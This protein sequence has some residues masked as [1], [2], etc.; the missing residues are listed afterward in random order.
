ML[1]WVHKMNC[2]LKMRDLKMPLRQCVLEEGKTC[3][4]CGECN[5]C[6]L[7]KRKICDNCGRCLESGATYRTIKIDTILPE[8]D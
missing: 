7:N 6:D 2:E 1:E 3:I 5:I 4:E 8:D